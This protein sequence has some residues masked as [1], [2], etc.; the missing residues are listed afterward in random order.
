MNQFLKRTALRIAAVSIVLASLASPVAWFVARQSAEE[1]VVSLAIEESG[2]LLRH[3]DAINLGAP[4]AV[5]HATVAA[6]AI[7]GGLFDIAEI[8]DAKGNKLA[9]SMTTEGAA[10]ESSL[11]KH[12]TLNNISATYQSL[13]LAG[14]R[15]TLRVFVPLRNP[16]NGANPPVTGYFEGVRVIPAW[17]KK[18]IRD[19][20]LSVALMVCLA[21]LLCGGAL[22]PVV[23]H[24]IGR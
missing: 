15:W 19:N 4:Q 3:F 16:G 8:Y 23:V 14:G 21:S 9:S 22:Y 7:S 5:E 12:G 11:P 17:Q 2:R 24:Q 13:K 18:Q 1:S 20:S 6:Q 10:V